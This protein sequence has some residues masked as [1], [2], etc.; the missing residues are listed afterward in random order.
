M[1]IIDTKAKSTT[2]LQHVDKTVLSN[3]LKIL[4]DPKYLLELINTTHEENIL[5][6]KKQADTL[7]AQDDALKAFQNSFR[8]LYEKEMKPYIISF[9]QYLLNENLEAEHVDKTIKHFEHVLKKFDRST[10]NLSTF[11]KTFKNATI[12]RD[13][14][15]KEVTNVLIDYKK[16]FE[17]LQ[18]PLVV[19]LRQDVQNN[20]INFFVLYPKFQRLNDW[21]EF[22]KEITQDDLLKTYAL[23]SLED[24]KSKIHDGVLV[25][26]LHIFIET[27]TRLWETENVNNIDWKEHRKQE[28]LQLLQLLQEAKK[29]QNIRLHYDKT[30]REKDNDEITYKHQYVTYNQ[31]PSMY[32]D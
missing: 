10:G 5:F 25:L 9:Q 1:D 2:L 24:Q 19:R 14:T 7:F 27:M 23:L 4:T 8:T 30:R 3:S 29:K 16:R 6:P 26:D 18:N 28:Q 11:F 21:G 12:D 22:T 13:P 15:L 32:F 17:Q 20:L 31:L